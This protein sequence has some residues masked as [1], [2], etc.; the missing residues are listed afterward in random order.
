MTRK[1]KRDHLATE[2]ADRIADHLERSREALSAAIGD[3]GFAV[4]VAA[5]AERIADAL[6]DGGKLLVA[7]NG[8]SAADAQHIAGEFLSRLHYDRAPLPA[9]ALTTDG[10]VLTAIGNDYGY[11][12]VF[13]RQVLG[14]G[15]PGDV[16]VAI[17]TSGRSPNIL[18]ALAASRRL[19]LLTVGLTGMSGGMMKESCDLCLCVPSD[20]T[21]IIQQLHITAAHIICGLVES[22][23]FPRP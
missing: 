15:R 8:G 14:L 16:F 13:E 1:Q 21:P 5:I 6:S 9:V 12:Q 23:L 11:E 2:I 3:P 17:S 22:R 7:G 20:S 10:S 4:M 19:G 18:R